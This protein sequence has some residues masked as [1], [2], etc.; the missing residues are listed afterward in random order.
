MTS[1]RIKQSTRMHLNHLKRDLK[2]SS[3]DELLCKFLDAADKYRE[4]E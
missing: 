3:I 4:V 1:V 2:C